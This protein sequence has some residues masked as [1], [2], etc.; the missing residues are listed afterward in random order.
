MGN[1]V[2][3]LAH[4]CIF[5]NLC[6]NYSRR[7][8]FFLFKPLLTKRQTLIKLPANI[9]EYLAATEPWMFILSDNKLK[10]YQGTVVFN[11]FPAPSG[12]KGEINDCSLRGGGDPLIDMLR[13]YEEKR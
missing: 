13:F 1:C 11:C 3:F 2:S 5:I 9:I 10:T 4:N 8:Y 6:F 7:L 12:L